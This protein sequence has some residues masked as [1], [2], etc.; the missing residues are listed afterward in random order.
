MTDCFGARFQSHP[1]MVADRAALPRLLAG[2][3]AQ[4]STPACQV[5]R[6]PVAPIAA[7]RQDVTVSETLARLR[8]PDCGQRLLL[9]SV[10]FIRPPGQVAAFDIPT[11]HDF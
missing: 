6:F 10:R 2:F 11:K 4:Y 3:V 8:C 1:N 5:R 9:P 7:A